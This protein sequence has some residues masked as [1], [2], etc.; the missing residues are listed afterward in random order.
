[1][2]RVAVLLGVCLLLAGL[3]AGALAGAALW[4]YSAPSEI[5]SLSLTP[6]G[7]YVLIGEGRLCFLAGNGTPLWQERTAK[8]AACSADGSLIAAASGPSLT[9]MDRNATVIWQEEVPSTGV[10]L[11]LSPNGKRIAMADFV[12]K[13]YFYDADGTLRAT[14][15]TRPKDKSKAV[16][17]EIRDVALSRGGEYA[18]VVSS[19]G[20]FY[21]TG[22]GRKVWVREGSLEGGTAAAVSGTGNEVAVAS[23]A[24][25]RL[26]NRTGSLL[27]TYRCPRPV[28]A[29]AIS[30]DGSRVL[31]GLQDNSLVCFDR[32]G[33]RIW[34]FTAGAWIRDVAVSKNGSRVL[35]G[36][37]DRQAYLFDG[38]GHLLDTYS[39]D[40]GIE[41]VA[42]T[43]DGT[44][45]VVASFRKVIG[46]STAAATAT[47]TAAGTTPPPP[48]TAT[49]AATP[50]PVTTAPAV[51]V[52]EAVTPTPA[53]EGDSGF[54]FLP[55]AGLLACSA[56]I[57]AGYLYRQHQ[58]PPLT[59]EAAVPEGPSA[60]LHVPEPAP[61]EVKE[62]PPAPWRVSL[63]QGR[64]REAARILSREMTVLIGQRAGV[65]VIYIVDAL[66][67]CPE[68][69]QDLARFF[70]DANR[71]AYASKD[72]TRE[73]IEA[74]EAAY[75]RLAEEISGGSRTD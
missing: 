1:M 28:T 38:A 42:L 10:A 6:D 41:H 45:G 60:P 57:G 55:I 63:E 69:R 19:C 9:L 5:T 14:V 49:S 16:I 33:E 48:S 30:E 11:A 56:A 52:Q 37:L 74:L 18:A 35:A 62:A 59:P 36:S 12:G 26:L 68:Q 39:L 32:E 53:P 20:L 22:A 29:L 21:Y 34:S 23:D 7:S 46:I 58:E 64:T 72:P 54:P 71:L 13:V 25:V 43:A 40:G 17:S 50:V 70:E 8:L 47:P 75:L 15:D 51:P 3:P 24:S 27:W 4:T 31:A 67:A 2:R 44:A 65:R 66:N 73:D 61:P